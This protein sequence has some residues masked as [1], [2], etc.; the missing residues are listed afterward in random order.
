MSDEKTDF[1]DPE[2]NWSVE[3]IKELQ[4]QLYELQAQ[5]ERLVIALDKQLDPVEVSLKEW[6]KR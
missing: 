1:K 4:E 6:I 5:F 3:T 2:R